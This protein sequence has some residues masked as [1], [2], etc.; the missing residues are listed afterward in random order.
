MHLETTGSISLPL[1]DQQY[2]SPP[3]PSEYEIIGDPENINKS[4]EVQALLKN[5]SC[6]S[7]N[8][9]SE[10]KCQKRKGSMHWARQLNLH[11]G[12]ADRT[13]IQH[14]HKMTLCAHERWGWLHTYSCYS[15]C[16]LI[17][18]ILMCVARIAQTDLHERICTNGF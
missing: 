12:G 11:S 1:S 4:H 8:S 14:F 6:L 15:C 9:C 2:F 3:M 18:A 16:I 13:F 7:Q 10:P 17:P 5:H